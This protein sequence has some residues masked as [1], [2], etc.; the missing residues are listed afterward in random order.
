[1]LGITSQP[2][3]HEGT[4]VRITVKK[5]TMDQ[6]RNIGVSANAG[7]SKL[8]PGLPTETSDWTANNAMFKLEGSKRAKHAY[9]R[10]MNEGKGVVNTG[11]GK[12]EALKIFNSNILKYE[13]LN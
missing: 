4:L 1:M 2:T 8:F 12:G 3:S 9:I 5:G 13:P 7:T 10:A 6:L 11:L